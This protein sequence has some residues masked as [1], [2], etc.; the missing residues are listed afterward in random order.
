MQVS[1]DA[2]HIRIE[3]MHREALCTLPF[4]NLRAVRL[5]TL[6]L[7]LLNRGGQNRARVFA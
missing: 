2:H 4:Q 3:Y 6:G 1:A 5:A 7:F